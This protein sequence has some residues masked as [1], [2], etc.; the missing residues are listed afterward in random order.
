MTDACSLSKN[1]GLVDNPETKAWFQEEVAKIMKS[2][3]T[4]LT[5]LLENSPGQKWHPNDKCAQHRP[6][7]VC[8]RATSSAR[9]RPVALPSPL[10]AS[11]LAP[12][13]TAPRTQ[14]AGAG[15][16]VLLSATG[17]SHP[18]I[19]CIERFGSGARNVL[20]PDAGMSSRLWVPHGRGLVRESARRQ[21]VF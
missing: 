6:P 9:G 2:R 1:E 19:S 10:P 14:A 5:L 16:G 8:S 21:S 15:Q 18:L 12:M 7:S 4:P 11:S 3:S 13:P 17:A 20:M